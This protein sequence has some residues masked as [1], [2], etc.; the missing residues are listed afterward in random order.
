M[1]NHTIKLLQSKQSSCFFPTS[2]NPL[3]ILTTP[4]NHSILLSKYL[5]IQ[6]PIL[7][8]F[9]SSFPKSPFS[10]ILK[11]KHPLQ[12]HSTLSSLLHHR[13]PILSH[14]PIKYKIVSRTISPN[15]A[16]IKEKPR[17]YYPLLLFIIL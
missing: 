10:P 11:N 1:N 9:L 4:P 6:Y 17:W 14:N 16:Q 13:N 7:S 5:Q 3:S 15:H 8:P 2:T 12:S